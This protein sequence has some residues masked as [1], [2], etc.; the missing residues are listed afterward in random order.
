MVGAGRAGEPHD[1]H[2]S[3]GEAWRSPEL[4][5]TTASIFG[6]LVG[7]LTC[8]SL[9]VR[10]RNAL[11]QRVDEATVSNAKTAIKPCKKFD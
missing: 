2:A 8:D 7:F 4:G 10:Y 1:R 5:K 9:D 3:K 6:P 11:V